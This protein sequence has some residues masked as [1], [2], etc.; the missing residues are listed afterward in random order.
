[1]VILRMKTN[2]SVFTESWP[3]ENHL[4]YLNV[5]KMKTFSNTQFSFSVIR[6]YVNIQDVGWLVGPIKLS[7][8]LRNFFKLILGLGAA[9][10]NYCVCVCVCGG[11]VFTLHTPWLS[12]RPRKCLG[13]F[14]FGV[15]LLLLVSTFLH[16]CFH[17]GL[18]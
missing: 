6:V 2:L 13:H 12:T 10:H 8:R 14:S 11:V 17:V 5:R 18:V 15:I 3:C 16:L 7:F 9:S 1:M 4:K